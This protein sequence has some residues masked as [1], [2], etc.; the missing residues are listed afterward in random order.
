MQYVDYFEFP[1][2]ARHPFG[3][4]N[5]FFPLPGYKNNIGNAGS[6]YNA[7]YSFQPD[8]TVNGID[9]ISISGDFIRL[10]FDSGFDGV[11]YPS[12]ANGNVKN[13]TINIRAANS[14]KPYL[15]TI[16]TAGGNKTIDVVS[17]KTDIAGSLKANSFSVN[18]EEIFFNGDFEC[19]KEIQLYSNLTL[20]GSGSM[21]S[22]KIYLKA[23]LTGINIEVERCG[24]IMVDSSVFSGSVRYTDEWEGTRKINFIAAGFGDID[25]FIPSG[26]GNVDILHNSGLINSHKYTY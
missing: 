1:V 13:E 23:D 5:Y 7:L 10:E 12:Q 4:M 6:G 21:K 24:D 14:A 8:K 3:F 20:S 11:K 25:V 22:P 16:G 15:I 19:E 17:E 26:S 9:R 2:M 18:S